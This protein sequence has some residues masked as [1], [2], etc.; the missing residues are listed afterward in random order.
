MN[1]PTTVKKTPRTRLVELA[2]GR[3]VKVTKSRTSARIQGNNVNGGKWGE[4][5]K[6]VKGW[7]WSCEDLDLHGL[8]RL[9]MEK[10]LLNECGNNVEFHNCSL[11]DWHL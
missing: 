4:L 11:P 3:T 9:A 8:T 10:A 6:T 1:L 7:S 5:A 2:D